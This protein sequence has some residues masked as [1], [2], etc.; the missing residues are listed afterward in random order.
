VEIQNSL[1][2]DTTLVSY[3]PMQDGQQSIGLLGSSSIR[4][5]PDLVALSMESFRL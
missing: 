3:C 2:I 1:T 5:V 4:N